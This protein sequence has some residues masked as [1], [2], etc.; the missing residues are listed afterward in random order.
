[1]AKIKDEGFA[2]IINASET[3]KPFGTIVDFGEEWHVIIFLFAEAVVAS[4]NW[5]SENVYII[6]NYI[7]KKKPI[8]S[9]GEDDSGLTDTLVLGFICCGCGGNLL[10]L[11]S[12]MLF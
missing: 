3:K 1:M 10:S 9:G 11:G 12:R 2:H 4:G 6:S 5:S 8:S 7:V